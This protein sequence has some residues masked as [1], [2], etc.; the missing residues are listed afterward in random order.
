MKSWLPTFVMLTWLAPSASFADIQELSQTELRSVVASSDVIATSRLIN[1]VERYTGG[2]VVEVRAFLVDGILAYRALVR[3]PDGQL[4]TIM[5]DGS[6]GHAITPT[7]RAGRQVT[8]LSRTPSA[9][10]T[11]KESN[12]NGRNTSSGLLNRGNS[13]G[14]GNGNGNNGNGNGN[15]GG[16]G[17]GS[18]GNGG[19]N[20]GGNSGGGN[21]G[22]NSGGSGAGSNGNG[23]GNSGGGGNGRGNNGNG[24]GGGSGA[25]SNGNGGGNSG[26]GNGRGNGRG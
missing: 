3:Q 2:Q 1:G 6:T 23:G 17:S 26:G 12:G 20:S 7:S 9:V 15:G 25:G 13:N 5:V 19:G 14:G 24:N 16:S 11:A 4:G 22:G 8:E 10:T 18:N 21:G